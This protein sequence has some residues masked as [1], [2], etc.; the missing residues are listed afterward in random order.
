M[1]ILTGRREA[2]ICELLQA[3]GTFLAMEADHLLADVALK[4]VKPVVDA[5][6]T[7]CR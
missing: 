3:T 5:V 7:P 2:R 6:R 4:M 1:G